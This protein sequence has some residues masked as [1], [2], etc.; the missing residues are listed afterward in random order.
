MIRSPVE[1][2]YSRRTIWVSAGRV[3]ISPGVAA[4][5]LPVKPPM[6]SGRSMITPAIGEVL[7]EG[8]SKQRAAVAPPKIASA[9]IRPTVPGRGGG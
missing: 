4:I 8:V 2:R 3:A 9:T 1:S 6:V 5:T 7:G